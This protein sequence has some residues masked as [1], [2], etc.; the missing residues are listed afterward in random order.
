[1]TRVETTPIERWRAALAEWAIP[2]EILAAAPESP[3]QLRPQQFA[4]RAD[5]ALHEE[6]PT[7]SRLRELEA[8]PH[9]GTVLDIG[10]GAGAASLPLLERASRLIVVDSDAAMIDALRARVPANIDLNVAHGMW[11]EV[12]GS[13]GEADVVV[14]H[15]VA[16]NLPNL[17]AAV[18]SMTDKARRRVVMELT[19]A[20]PRAAQ[21]F[22]WPLF[23]GIERPTRPTADD[24][25]AVIREC[26][27]E[28]QHEEWNRSDEQAAS[29]DL[30]EL[31][32]SI[33]RYLCLSP[34]RDP[35]VADALQGHLVTRGEQVGLPS[36]PVVTVWWD[37]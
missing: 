36:L 16:Y 1:M 12:A 23:H 30:P 24:A 4:A 25:I 9:G 5:R 34:D 8:I 11:P 19:S 17:D 29:W 21:N 26:G 37:V 28:A 33:R 13:V 18:L 10:A 31:V 6:A 20:H 3:W 35:E 14:C 27:F 2:P 15:H 22:L 32:A 7:T